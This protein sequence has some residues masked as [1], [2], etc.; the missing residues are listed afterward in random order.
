M[1]IKKIIRSTLGI[2]DHCVIR[3][4]GDTTKL[5]I[6]L[7]LIARRKLPCS[8][9]GTRSPVR[10]RL[11]ERTWRHVPLWNI[12]VF[13]RYRSARV[14]CPRCG[15]KVE[16]IPWSNGKSSL[17]KPLSLAMATWAKR[18]PMNVVA[19]IFGVCWN[20]VY[21]AVNQVVAYGLSRRSKTGI[22]AL[23]IDEISRKKGHTYLTQ[24]YDLTRKRL[25]DSIENRTY[26]SLS[27][28]FESWGRANLNNIKGVCCDMWDPY[29][30]AIKDYLPDAV[31]VF[32][33]FHLIRQLLNAVNDVRKQEA[34]ILKKTNPELLTGTRYIW[35]KNPWN[36]TEKQK[37]R[38]SY[39]E[40]LNLKINRAYLLK[41]N[42]RELWACPN[43]QEAKKFLDHWF[44]LAT[45][46]RIPQIRKFAWMVRNHQNGIL[47]WFDLPIDNGAVEALNN[48]AKT[49]SHQAKGYRSSKTFSTILMHCMGK[50]DSPNWVHKFA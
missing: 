3:V 16:K 23:G 42:F 46:S 50:L 10:D 49:I 45:H 41:E 5:V 11:S 38:L 48:V 28:F 43:G 17:S 6:E 29:I 8:R 21:S 37:Q 26:E 7:D 44:W 30:K 19:Q 2:K 13:I 20:A 18:L 25:L 40:K 34:A 27:S 32:D 35:L 15:I 47:A 24:I 39:L 31:I 4:T 14:K 36:L 12:P 1:L 9:C 33:K 22:I